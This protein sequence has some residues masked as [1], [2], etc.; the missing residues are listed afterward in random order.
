M[1][2]A[3]LPQRLMDDEGPAWTSSLADPW[4]VLGLKLSFGNLRSV[5]KAVQ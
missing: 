4:T 3:P 5:H 1:F 2:T